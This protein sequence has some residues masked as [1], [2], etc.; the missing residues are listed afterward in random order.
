MKAR[1]DEKERLLQ[2]QAAEARRQLEQQMQEMRAQAQAA[3]E[4]EE[5][6]IAALRA[7][8]ESMA[9]RFRAMQREAEM[10]RL[11]SIGGR[12]ATVAVLEEQSFPH[13]ARFF[14]PP[15]AQ[16]KRRTRTRQNRRQKSNALPKRAR[17]SKPR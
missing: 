7:E 1:E 5:S 14:S 6:R 3:A 13:P 12:V 17:G 11:F 8:E 15:R 16:R 4:A 9:E 10:K 2:E